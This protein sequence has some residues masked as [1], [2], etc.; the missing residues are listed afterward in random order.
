MMTPMDIQ[1]KQFDKAMM[2]YNK[3]D[4]ESFLDC[5]AECYEDLYNQAK[6]NEREIESLTEKLET[7]KN[8][9]ESINQSLIVAQQTAETVQKNAQERADLIIKEAEI[10][11]KEITENAEKSIVEA[12]NA[13][14][15]MQHAMDIYKCQAI[16]ML[17]AQ[18]ENLQKFET[19]IK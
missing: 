11:A 15:K 6:T 1:T 10:R 9:E 8:I 18:I 12:Q 2:G 13:L 17:N 16:S 5:I 4:V 3:D 7:Y 19:T 14:A